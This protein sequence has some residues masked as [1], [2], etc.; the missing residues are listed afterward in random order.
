MAKKTV[1]SGIVGCGFSGAFHFSALQKVHGTDVD[2]VGVYDAD[3]Q[4]RAAYA[5][6]RGIRAFE[7]L[8]ALL[9][10]VEIVHVCVTAT[11]HESVAVAA[12]ERHRFAIV[13]K[14]LTGYFGDGSPDFN[15]DTCS[16]ETALEQALASVRRMLAAEAASEG[17]IL[18]AENW[19]YAPAVQKEREIIEKT[20]AQILWMHGEEAHS[21]SHATTYAHWKYSGGGVMIGKGCHPLTAALYLKR[22]EGR[23]R[24]GRPI[25]PKA[26]S[27]RTHAITRLPNF[28]DQGHLRSNYHDI[29]DFSMMHVVFDDGTVATVFASDIV[30][31]GIHNWLEVAANNHRTVCNINPN[32]AM[33]TYNPVDSNFDDI[34]VV[35]KTGTKQ[36]WSYPSPDE[37]WFT[38]YPQEIEAFYRTV[39]YGA[40]PESDSALAAD[41]IA[42]TYSAYVSAERRGAEVDV[43]RL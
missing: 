35:E 1:R 39:A 36:G 25:R 23:A 6:Q 11:A 20:G 31:G 12:L 8:D 42:T 13:E 30:M 24:G 33:Q 15:G 34:Y 29:D 14:P 4:R 38:G 3:P 32:T 22:V 41:C 17:R 26:V 27:A 37:D 10:E 21:G 2:C 16:K 18:Y 40:A 7:T 28:I 19:V 5:S 9:D 43:E